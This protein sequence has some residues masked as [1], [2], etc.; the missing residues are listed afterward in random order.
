MMEEFR[1]ILADSA[2]IS[3]IN[4]GVVQPGDF[5]VRSTGVAI[6]DAARKR[7]I[8][9]YER[10]LD[11]LATHPTFGTRLSMRRIL[12]VQ[13]RLLGKVLLGELE[14]YPEYRVR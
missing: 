8:Q 13:V 12:E 4:N 5:I 7:F 14:T 1:P 6:E 11:E 10:R 2:V 3:A 9:V